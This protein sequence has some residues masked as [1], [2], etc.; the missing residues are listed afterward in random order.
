MMNNVAVHLAL[1]LVEH[2]HVAFLGED[3][4]STHLLYRV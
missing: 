1:F 2:I 3:R 4:K